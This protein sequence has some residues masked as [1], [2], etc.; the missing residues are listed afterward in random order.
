MHTKT[1]AVAL[2]SIVLNLSSVACVFAAPPAQPK[3]NFLFIYTDDQR[4]DAMSC[5]QKEQG[6]R[7]RFPWFQTPNLDRLASQGIRFRNAFVVNSL[8]APSRSCFLTGKY[9]HLNGVANNHT[10]MPL[11]TV[12]YA[13]LL[14]TAGYTTGYFGKFHHDGQKERPGF[15]QIYSFIGQGKY[16][17]CPFNINGDIKPT[18]GWVDDVTT[19]FA[20]D[21]LKSRKA[22]EPFAM[23]VGFKSPHAPRT[24]PER[25]K[26]RFAGEEVRPVPNLTV[27]APY[28][29]KVNAVEDESS[30]EAARK[31]GPKA[32]E[33][34]LQ[35]FRTISAVDDNVGRLLDELDRLRLRDNTI[36]VFTSDNGFYLGE[37][38]LG[39][40]RS[41]YEESIRI[42]MLIR[43]PQSIPAGQTRDEIVLNIDIAPTFLGYAG[44][45]APPDM[46]GRDFRGVIENKL[47]DWRGSFFYTYFFETNFKIPTVTAVRT[48]D[49]KLIKYPGHDEWTELFD[50][51]NDPYELKNLINDPAAK[52]LKT[53]LESTYDAQAKAI[54]FKIPDFA[55]KP[56]EKP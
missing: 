48:T 36:V 50:L 6:D 19:D 54:D 15:D 38:Q 32:K 42:P 37:H 9:S 20:I 33:G 1:L 23:V 53:Q 21:F 44:I 45:S 7:A 28:L 8:C 16:E 51:K 56:A 26:D 5:V 49:A 34:L 10:P 47:G 24:P 31:P 40:K 17:D 41:A 22:D 3:P 55:D 2:A 18:R 27:R 29:P 52:D 13:H 46:Q 39:D 4:W 30:G 11:D 25:A 12:T 35:Y 14:K 43:Y